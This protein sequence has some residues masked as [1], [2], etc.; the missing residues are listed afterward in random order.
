MSILLSVFAPLREFQSSA[1]V[2]DAER[3]EEP[4]SRRKTMQEPRRGSQLGPTTRR[5]PCVEDELLLRQHN[6]K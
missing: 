3:L 5:G 1:G 2:E 4:I 6:I